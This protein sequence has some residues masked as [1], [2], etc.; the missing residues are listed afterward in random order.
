MEQ[1]LIENYKKAGKI[2]S[3]VLAY[4]KE[5]IKKDKK[6][7]DVCNKIESKIFEL[8]A[9]PAF[10]V[11]ISCNEI[12]AHYTPTPEE[13][14]I[15]EKGDLVKIDL[16]TCINGYISDTAITVEI[17]TNENKELIKA[18][19]EA[20]KEAIK[21]CQI[22]TEIWQIGKVIEE[23][24]S[25]YGFNSIK[26]LSGHGLGNYEVHRKPT[27]PNFNNENKETLQKGQFI[28]IEPFATT[29]SGYV[30]EGKPSTIYAIQK[31]QSIRNPITKKIYDYAEKEYKILPF[32]KRQL[33]KKFPLPQ[34]NLALKDLEN[35]KIIKEYC[36]L[37]EKSNGLVSQHEHTLLIDEKVIV[38]TK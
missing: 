26:N 30:K 11:Q 7:L 4:G 27:I 21:I 14:T 31:K 33:L 2:A 13:K 15:F 29:G 6:L 18:S 24:I 9:K 12:A 1:E 22:G 32:C 28:T 16:G 23:T 35:N 20:L 5:L 25:S 17:K 10:P 34:V 36:Q 38:L 3:E 19:D 37:P 8:G